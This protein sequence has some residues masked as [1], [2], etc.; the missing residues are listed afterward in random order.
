MVLGGIRGQCAIWAENLCVNRG[1]PSRSDSVE[2]RGSGRQRTPRNQ[3]GWRPPGPGSQE[4]DVL[5]GPNK[6]VGDHRESTH[7]DAVGAV[8]SQGPGREV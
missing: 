5:G 2:A 8:F 4:V 1:S 7:H 3:P 6:A